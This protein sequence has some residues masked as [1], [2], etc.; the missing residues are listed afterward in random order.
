MGLFCPTPDVAAFVFSIG[1][2]AAFASEVPPALPTAPFF[3]IFPRTFCEVS[4]PDA[5]PVASNPVTLIVGPVVQFGKPIIFGVVPE[6]IDPSIRTT[7]V[8]TFA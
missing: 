7:R 3:R 6:A 5:C 8:Q 2:I 1:I 4:V